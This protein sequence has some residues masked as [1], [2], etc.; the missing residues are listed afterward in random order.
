VWRGSQGDSSD[1]ADG[2]R[3]RSPFDDLTLRSDSWQV[4][5]DVW[6]SLKLSEGVLVHEGSERESRRMVVRAG[7]KIGL[8]PTTIARSGAQSDGMIP[9]TNGRKPDC[10][11]QSEAIRGYRFVSNRIGKIM[12][13]EGATEKNSDR[14]G[15]MHLH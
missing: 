1:G 12:R 15:P 10:M 14:D 9:H 5:R 3:K 11:A 7:E 4:R 6:H 2:A 13:W 8:K